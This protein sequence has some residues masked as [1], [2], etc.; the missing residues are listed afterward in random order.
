M[1]KY[2]PR[3]WETPFDHS[4]ACRTPCLVQGS[5]FFSRPNSLHILPCPTQAYEW[6][7]DSTPWRNLF[8]AA[9]AERACPSHTLLPGELGIAAV[10]NWIKHNPWCCESWSVGPVCRDLH[11]RTLASLARMKNMMC[12]GTTLKDLLARQEIIRR[13]HLMELPSLLIAGAIVL[14]LCQIL[15]IMELQG[16]SLPYIYLKFPSQ[17]SRSG[18]G[19]GMISISAF[20]AEGSRFDLVAR[21]ALN[22]IEKPWSHGWARLSQSGW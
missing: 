17:V 20:P 2:N 15:P 1:P 5:K 18:R 4:I 14:T 21:K 13:R 6:R 8:I 10:R 16:W 19:W 7:E 3:Y 9:P 12:S 22:R 11:V